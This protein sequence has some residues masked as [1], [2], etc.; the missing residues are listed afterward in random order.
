M[1]YLVKIVF[2]HLYNYMMRQMYCM[3]LA[4]QDLQSSNV[5]KDCHLI[6]KGPKIDEMKLNELKP[7]NI[8]ISLNY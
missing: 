4:M 5:N 6:V 1:Q 8:M 7:N 3:S 2:V